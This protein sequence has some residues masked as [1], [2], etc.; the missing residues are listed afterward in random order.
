MTTTTACLLGGPPRRASRE[1]DGISQES[2]LIFVA[3]HLIDL[4]GWRF[5]FGFIFGSRVKPYG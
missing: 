3:S 2:P 1:T 4:L 5:T